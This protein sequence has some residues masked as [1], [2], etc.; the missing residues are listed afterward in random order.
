MSGIRVDE[1]PSWSSMDPAAP[2][3]VNWNSHRNAAGEPAKQVRV[4][5]HRKITGRLVAMR[6]AAATK[7][8]G[9]VRKTMSDLDDVPK[10]L[11]RCSHDR[12]VPR[13]QGAPAGVSA[14]E[15]AVAGLVALAVAMG[16]CRFA[17]TPILPM[18]LH[19]GV[20]DLIGASWLASANYLGYLAGALFS[21]FQPRL[22]VR[23]RIS[24]EIDGPALVRFGLASTVL[25][26][27]GMVLPLPALWPTLR[28]IAGVAS[29]L[30]F[31]YS[32]A[33]CLAQVAARNAPALGGVMFAGP[34]VGIVASGLVASLLVALDESAAVAWLIFSA[35]ALALTASVWRRFAPGSNRSW[36]RCRAMP[37]RPLL[38]RCSRHTVIPKC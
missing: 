21:T 8:I 32:S 3:H 15:I 30:V 20:V 19:D 12:P 29:A 1:L 24:I 36:Q 33:W 7:P 25:L 2:I 22:R 38:C 10:L 28:F 5:K 16:I 31:V 11:V 4:G 23:L 35:L 6:G 37:C 13:R 27:L 18:M 26:T 9:R 17:F 34:G 14:I